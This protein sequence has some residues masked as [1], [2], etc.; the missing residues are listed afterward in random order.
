MSSGMD[1]KRL[2]H[3]VWSSNIPLISK[4]KLIFRLEN[5]CTLRFGQRGKWGPDVFNDVLA[6]A[7]NGIRLPSNLCYCVHACAFDHVRT[8][9]QRIQNLRKSVEQLSSD[10]RCIKQIV[11]CCRLI[12]KA[13]DFTSLDI[14][15]L[16]QTIRM[17]GLSFDKRFYLRASNTRS[18][19][20]ATVA[21]Y[22]LCLDGSN[23][24]HMVSVLMNTAFHRYIEA[25]D[26]LHVQGTLM[27]T[28][29][30]D[31]VIPKFNI[32]LSDM[33]DS[34]YMKL[35]LRVDRNELLKTSFIQIYTHKMSG[36]LDSWIQN[37]DFATLEVIFIGES[38]YG[39]GPVRDWLSLLIKTLIDD[40]EVSMFYKSPCSGV[41]CFKENMEHVT[42]N[43]CW[44]TGIVL[45]LCF[46]LDQ[47]IGA[48]FSRPV[49]LALQGMLS[50]IDLQD[51]V[52]IDPV[53][54][55]T[56]TDIKQCRSQE[57]LDALG[58]SCFMVGDVEIAPGGAS[59]PLLVENIDYFLKSL[60]YYKAGLYH[61]SKRI[62]SMLLGMINIIA[63]TDVKRLR[64]FLGE[65][66]MLTSN[67]LNSYLG[68]P[69]DKEAILERLEA[70]VIVH[71]DA[72]VPIDEAMKDDVRNKFMCHVRTKDVEYA[73][74]LVQ[75]WTGC[76]A[77]PRGEILQLYISRDEERLPCA[78]TCYYQLTIPMTLDFSKLDVA[79]ANTDGT[80]EDPVA[81]S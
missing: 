35:T 80:I 62:K 40:D 24:V 58:I 8:M 36:Y 57:E 1:I 44:M 5:L 47:R 25:V 9:A 64:D 34:T 20:E 19:L 61:N 55:R 46:R 68:S 53:I 81:T 66:R 38:G 67:Q 16:Q 3:R 63:G 78:Q 28:N 30:F 54:L 50:N 41:L 32:S 21:L 10:T 72:D 26:H 42:D 39:S 59:L 49:L 29:E 17:L 45:G 18:L 13:H 31:S 70:C 43:A 33:G 71:I 73:K 14:G 12:Y 65:C 7:S 27:Y 75:F 11:I 56:C 51:L 69:M 48:F 22:K 74:S 15:M 79:I 52:D 76:L 23:D 4:E 77:V 60:V 37:E 6:C 2:L